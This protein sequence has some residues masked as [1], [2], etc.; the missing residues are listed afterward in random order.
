MA[1]SKELL[2]GPKAH[3][4]V[5]PQPGDP[6]MDIGRLQRY[7]NGDRE[8]SELKRLAVELLKQCGPLVADGRGPTDTQP[9]PLYCELRGDGAIEVLAS[10]ELEYRRKRSARNL[11]RTPR[12]FDEASFS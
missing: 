11:E 12:A 10:P 9:R 2:V 5:Q 3:L 4:K 7:V 6:P 8:D 1:R